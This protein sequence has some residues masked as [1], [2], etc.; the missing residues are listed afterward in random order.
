[1]IVLTVQTVVSIACTFDIFLYNDATPIEFINRISN[2]SDL[3][4]PWFVGIMM[5][6]KGNPSCTIIFVCHCSIYRCPF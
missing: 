4:F 6:T 3:C 2:R 1:M 5:Y